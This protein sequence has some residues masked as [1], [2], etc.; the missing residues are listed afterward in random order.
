M[1]KSLQEGKT[2]VEMILKQVNDFDEVT[3][4]I[5]PPFTY[6]DSINSQISNKE[7]CSS[8]CLK[9]WCIICLRANRPNQNWCGDTFIRYL[10]A[11]W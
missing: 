4:I 11:N 1:N 2:L 8:G 5:I 10:Y 7:N 9:S 6:L 3:K